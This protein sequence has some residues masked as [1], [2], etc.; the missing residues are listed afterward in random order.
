[1]KSKEYWSQRAAQRM[2]RYHK[3]ADATGNDV[4]LYYIKAANEIEEEI[5]KI[6]RTFQINGGLS[7]KDARELLN[8]KQTNNLREL[9]RSVKDPELRQNLLNI[10][11]APAYAWRI[12]RYEQLQGEIDRYTDILANHEVWR[13]RAHYV[14]LAD[15]AYLRT[16]FDLQRGT[17][18]GFSFSMLPEKK[19]IGILN[20][21]WSGKLFS[22]RIWGKAEKVNAQLKEELAIGFL[23]GRS[24]RK[25]AE[26]I[27]ARL[28]VGAMEARRLVRTESTYIANMAEL[29]SYKECEIDRY[30]FLATLDMRT[31]D[32]CAAMDGKKFDVDK[33][34]PGENLPPL[35][36]WCRSTTIAVIDRITESKLERRARDPETGE[37]YTISVDI[38][39]GEWKKELDKKYG[40]GYFET[41]RKMVLN[42]KQDRKQYK[43]YISVLG[44]ENMPKT[45]DLF[46]KMKYNS[47]EEWEDLKYY[48]RNIDGRPIEYVKIDREL[49]KEGIIDK[50]KAYPIE[51]IEV[52]GWRSHALK[53][54]TERNATE[55]QA[56]GYQKNAI[57]MM[58]KFPFPNTQNNYYS[59]SGVIGVRTSDGIVCTI[60]TE[61]DFGDYTLKILEVFKKWLK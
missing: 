61:N 36:A 7:E 14:E 58:K 15:E 37:T 13:T 50:G 6:F 34:V 47:N 1:M 3:M 28:S 56:I 45:F 5:G 18:I 11:N 19:V 55:E 57:G 54:L 16:V 22:E 44:A 42:E 2:Y 32:I 49:Q 9:V 23:T 46:R 60:Y 24:Y 38:K 35:H 26:A 33:A 31:S 59:E 40:E 20:Q 17:G 25:T 39:Y 48:F 10:V 29:E 41:K 27:E 8:D 30:E 51:D 4:A 52:K 43:E 53:R 21:N 12:R